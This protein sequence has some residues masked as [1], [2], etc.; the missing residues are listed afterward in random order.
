MGALGRAL[1]WLQD[2]KHA[3]S[4]LEDSALMDFKHI[5][6]S[7]ALLAE[8]AADSQ[9]FRLLD[10]LETAKAVTQDSKGNVRVRQGGTIP[11]WLPQTS[12][13]AKLASVLSGG[14]ERA[15]RGA[16]VTHAAETIPTEKA[17]RA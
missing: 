11:T 14:L 6:E 3:A 9:A 5:R 7:D 4:W 2:L 16:S 1:L 10:A 17:K 15:E 12:A 13:L 8:G